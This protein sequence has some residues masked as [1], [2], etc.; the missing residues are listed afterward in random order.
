ML[1]Q[2]FAAIGVSVSLNITNSSEIPSGHADGSLEM[3][4]IARNFSLIPDPIGTVLSDYAPTGDWGAM[5]WDN[6][7]FVDLARGIARG[8]GGAEARAQA[9][10]IL[11]EELPVIPI[12]WYRQTL[13]VTRG[14]EG[15]VIDPFERTFG[16]QDLQWV[17]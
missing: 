4:L 14:V 17:R 7:A 2:Q 8:E 13:A 1:E 15:T 12:A 3:A 16:L 10:A 6:P 9:A 5:G 11:Q